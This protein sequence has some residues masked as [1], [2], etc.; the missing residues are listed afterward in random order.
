MWVILIYDVTMVMTTSTSFRKQRK[1]KFCVLFMF[2]NIHHFNNCHR[3]RNIK[4][5]IFQKSYQCISVKRAKVNLIWEKMA[6]RYRSWFCSRYRDLRYPDADTM[7]GLFYY[8]CRLPVCNTV[9]HFCSLG[10]IYFH[11]E[12]C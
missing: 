6:P 8:Y 10:G 11:S 9:A 7:I 12:L 3:K 5:N 2:P 4:Y 1:R